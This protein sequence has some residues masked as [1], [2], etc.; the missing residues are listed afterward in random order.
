MGNPIQISNYK[1]THTD[2][3]NINATINELLEVLGK[4]PFSRFFLIMNVDKY[5]KRLTAYQFLQY[6]ITIFEI[7]V[8]LYPA[9][10]E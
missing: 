5:V 9:I 3:D 7:Y 8:S 10:R 1:E 6:I 4:K 2:K